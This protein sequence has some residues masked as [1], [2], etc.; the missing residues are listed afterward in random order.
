MVHGDRKH[1]CDAHDLIAVNV[2]V[3][4]SGNVKSYSLLQH[5]VLSFRFLKVWIFV[6]VSFD[7]CSIYKGT[8]FSEA[9]I[10]YNYGSSINTFHPIMTRTKATLVSSLQTIIN[11]GE[12]QCKLSE[13]RNYHGFLIKNL[14]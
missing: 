5:S 7:S 11:N 4:L 12:L 10:T 3:F 1:T 8:G 13:E 9:Q 14:D 2:H 6:A